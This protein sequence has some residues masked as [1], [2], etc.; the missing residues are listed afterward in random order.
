[1]ENGDPD[2][3]LHL[4]FNQHYILFSNATHRALESFI[5][6]SFSHNRARTSNGNFAWHFTKKI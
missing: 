1:M 3:D 5:E 6:N 2:L 4:S